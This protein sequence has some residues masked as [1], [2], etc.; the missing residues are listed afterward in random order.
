MRYTVSLVTLGACA[1]KYSGVGSASNVHH[2][3]GVLC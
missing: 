1:A 3:K 2:K